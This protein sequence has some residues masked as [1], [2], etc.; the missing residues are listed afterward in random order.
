MASLRSTLTS[1]VVGA[2][3]A[4]LSSVVVAAGAQ[5]ADSM[6]AIAD[7][8]IRVGLLFQNHDP[9]PYLYFGPEALRTEARRQQ[10]PLADVVPQL[11]ALRARIEALPATAA[12]EEQRRRRDLAQRITA[13]VTRG[14]ILMGDFPASFDEEVRL[15]FDVQVPRFDEAHFRAVTAKLD[16]IIPGDGDLVT[17]VEAFREQFVIPPERLEAV[18]TRAISECRARAR[19]HLELPADEQVTLSMTTGKHW[20][21]FAEY[22]GKS[23]STYH[24]NR[25]IPVHIERAIE[26]GCHE[27]YPGHHVHATLVDQELVGRRG[28]NEYT[29]ITLLGPL[30]VVAEGAANFGVDLAFSRQQ[31]IEFDRTVLMPLAGLDGRQ[32][33]TYYHYIDLLDELNFARNEVARKYLY[34]GL[35]REQAVQWLMEFGLETRATASQRI[36][37]IDTQRVYVITYNHG[38]RLVRDYVMTKGQPGSSEAWQAFQEILTTPLSPADLLAATATSTP[39]VE[40]DRLD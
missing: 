1:I 30:A 33:E 26:L 35:P 17:R 6:S 5:R 12:P 37:F 2:L 16:S 29:L 3:L 21:G 18:M 23:Q 19:A 39:A 27:A 20:V 10:V 8:F 7:E 31:R 28:W 38:K 4:L 22:R 34:E 36:D 25:D 11:I 13:T 32:L 40:A 9:S 24:L 14:G 15:L